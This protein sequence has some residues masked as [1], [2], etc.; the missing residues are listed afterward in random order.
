MVHAMMC[1]RWIS[2]RRSGACNGG[3][4]VAMIAA[5]GVLL[6]SVPARA[7]NANIRPYLVGAR[8]AGMGGAAT[9]LADD[10]A[11]PYYNPGGIAF[12]MAASVVVGVGLRIRERNPKDGISP[13]HDFTYSDINTFPVSTSAVFKWGPRAERD[14]RRLTP[15]R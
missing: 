6:G 13:G 8:A 14:G 3:V 11:G 15:W 4:A 10:G 1:N 5:C 9:A 12:A 2:S 7:D